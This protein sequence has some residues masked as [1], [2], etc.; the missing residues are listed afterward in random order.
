MIHLKATLGVPIV[1][2]LTCTTIVH[3]FDIYTNDL[4]ILITESDTS[5]TILDTKN[6]IVD[7]IYT[8][9]LVTTGGFLEDQLGVIDTRKV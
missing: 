1:G 4:S 7:R 6:V 2:S 5:H 9:K 8:V 3:S